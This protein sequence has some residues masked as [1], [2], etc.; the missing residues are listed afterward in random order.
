M[1]IVTL[2]VI[3]AYCDASSLPAV[4][5]SYATTISTALNSNTTYSCSLGYQA[6]PTNGAP[7]AVCSVFNQTSGAYTLNSVSC[8][9]TDS[10]A[11]KCTVPDSLMM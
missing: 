2:V 9:G 7:V 10:V 11:S 3:P 4:S 5:N 6:N 8:D 1:I